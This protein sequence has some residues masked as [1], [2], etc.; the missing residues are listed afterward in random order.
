MHRSVYQLLHL[1]LEGWGIMKFTKNIKTTVKKIPPVYLLLISIS[2]ILISIIIHLAVMIYANY[3]KWTWLGNRPAAEYELPVDV[4]NEGQKDDRLQFQGTELEDDFEADD[5]MFD[6]VPEIEYRPVIPEVEILPDPKASDELDFISVDASALDAKWVTPTTGGKPLDTGAEMLVGS[7]SRHIQLM[8]E[9]GLDVVFVFDSTSSMSGYLKQ[10]KMKIRNLAAAF[11]KLVPTCRIGLVTYRDKDDEYVTKHFPL[12]HGVV[13]L[14]N[15]LIDIGYGGGY[16]IR[17]AV[18]DGLRVAIR[19]M[20]WNRKSKKFIL[21]IGDA[22]PHLEDMPGAVKMI[23]HF[24]D[25]MGGKLSVLDI[26]QPK[27]ITRYYWET[28]VQ[29]NMTDP[30]IESWEFLTDTQGVMDDFRTL[31][32]VGGGEGARLINEEKVIKHM[33]LLIFGTR[34]EMYLDEFMKNL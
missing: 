31:A 12:T 5:D 30:G 13:S 18:A 19:D 7:F 25:N 17:E 32:T 20:K 23:Q 11:R 16:D 1:H 9:G 34:W 4:L 27:K 3:V 10:V 33:L 28:Y 6:P 21:L 24:R 2:P 29:P 15:F 8:R 14:H 26:R 22:P